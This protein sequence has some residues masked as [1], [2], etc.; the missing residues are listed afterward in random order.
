M[1]INLGARYVYFALDT[2]NI[3]SYSAYTNLYVRPTVYLK[4]SI[5]LSGSGTSLDPYVI[6]E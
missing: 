5:V 4:S 3:Y 6:V 2:G 1:V